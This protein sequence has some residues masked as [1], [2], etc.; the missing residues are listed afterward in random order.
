MA[1]LF[2]PWLELLLPHPA[3]FTQDLGIAPSIPGL[4]HSL[5]AGHSFH[6]ETHSLGSQRRSAKIRTHV[7]RT[8]ISLILGRDSFTPFPRSLIPCQDAL[9]QIPGSLIPYRDALIQ[10]PGSLIPYRDAFTPM[11]GPL[12][13]HD[14]R[15]TFP[16]PTPGIRFRST[17]FNPL[18]SACARDGSR[19]IRL[20]NAHSQHMESPP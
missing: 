19:S 11:P 20:P 13:P 7:F 6:S 15:S 5:P 14:P 8:H 2:R 16:L 10:I 9:I 3:R 4:T 18:S 1:G 17:P 12:R